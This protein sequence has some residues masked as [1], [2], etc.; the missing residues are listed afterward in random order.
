MPYHNLIPQD[1]WEPK[2]RFRLRRVG[3]RWKTIDANGSTR[4]ARGL[5]LYVV[6]GGELLVAKSINTLWTGLR[7]GH[8]DL[9]RGDD[10]EYAGE[11]R[12]RSGYNSRGTLVVWNNQSGHYLPRA[13]DCPI[14]PHLPQSHFRGVV[15]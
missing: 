5:F 1:I 14:V 15:P 3:G 12:F 7:I 13:E 10:V 8:I 4:T 9:A 11:I 6:Q 2:P